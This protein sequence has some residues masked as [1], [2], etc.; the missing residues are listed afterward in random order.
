VEEPD[1]FTFYE[2]WGSGE[3]PDAHLA[4]PHLVDFAAR[5][6]DHRDDAA[7]SP[8][9]WGGAG[10]SGFGAMTARTL[11]DGQDAVELVAGADPELGIHV[12]EVVLGGAR[13]DEQAGP[14]SPGST[15][16]PWPAARP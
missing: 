3:K 9:I 6:G 5:M 13:A 4:A 2:N 7:T 10:I 12:A 1:S 11:A 8:G 14:R 16:R 15:A